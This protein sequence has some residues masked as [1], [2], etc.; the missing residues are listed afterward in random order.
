MAR[1]NLKKF[2][3][4]HYKG[5]VTARDVIREGITNSIH[6]GAKSI[7][8]DLWFEKQAGLFGDEER[9]V[10]DKITISDD[11]EGF[12]QEN[13]NYFD[14]I[15]TGH[16]DDIGGK[17]VGRLAFLKYANR[18]EIWS[19]L[20][21]HLVEFRYTAEFKLDDVKQTATTG[22]QKTT[23][24]ISELKD[25]INTQVAKLVN[26]M[27]DDLRLLLFLKR[28]AGQIVSINFTH[29]SRQQFPED[30]V[31]SGECIEALKKRSFE[32]CGE[33]FDCYLFREDMP[34]KGIIAMLC[35][36]ELCVEECHISKRFDSCRYLISITSPYLNRSS[37]IERQKLE[38][39]KTDEDT[40]LV[41]PISREKLVP[42]IH[43]ECLAMVDEVGKGDIETF[44][45]A[46]IEKLKTYYP[47]ITLDSLSGDAAMLD[48]DQVVKTYRAQQ[49]RREDQLVEAMEQGRKVD[50]DDISHLASHDLARFIIHRALLID[51]LSKMPRES[52]EHVLHNAIL[53][54]NS[55]GNDI[56]E[57][58]IWLVDDKFL[59]Y[60][61]IY[62]DETLAK[63]IRDVGA[64]TESKQ[65]R[66]PD[67]AAF[68]SKD[69]EG[70]PNKLVII[71]FKKPG[72]DIFENNKALVQ[73]R[74]YASELVDRISTVRE[75]FAFSIVE[76]DDEFYKD[77]KRTGFKDVFSLSER[78]VYDDFNI[79][80]SDNIP[81]HLYVMPTSSLII[82]AKARNRVF[83][84]VLRFNMTYEES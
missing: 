28:Q 69:N 82:D 75:V 7:S 22:K 84:E 48:A 81:L 74:L 80:S 21:T 27:C 15:C 17:G 71:E 11:G 2:I 50:F 45:L 32:M 10:L 55:D 54:K 41:S 26:S 52:A 40:D 59:S 29:N 72:A 46:N 23:I 66:K 25:K 49:A 79:G 60:S 61:S 63:I 73:C 34:R 14:E 20:P 42:R 65:Q 56:R 68:F 35:A 78:V 31:F 77:M 1:I 62:S 9:N 6:A 67:V 24:I 13:L 51:S 58:N 3:A 19:Q 36:D 39:P 37:D 12:T 53:R 76:I 64:E 47:F 57:N 18:V 43:E 44:K 8:V 5:G 30:F 4:E 33:T 70:H 16:K 38:L 83:E